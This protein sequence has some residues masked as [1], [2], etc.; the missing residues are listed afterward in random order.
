MNRPAR[1]SALIAQ[2]AGA[3]HEG[4]TVAAPHAANDANP[5]ALWIPRRRYPLDSS[6]ADIFAVSSVA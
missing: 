3:A 1:R 4:D 5:L 6:V 2:P